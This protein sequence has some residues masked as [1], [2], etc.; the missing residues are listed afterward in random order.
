MNGTQA[1]FARH[2]GV[3][4]SSVKRAVDAGRLVLEADGTLDFE[5]SVARWHATTGGRT[6]VAARHA[7][8]RGA[9]IPK[10]AAGAKNGTAAPK[11]SDTAGLD[12]AVSPVGDTSRTKA[13]ALLVHYENSTIKLGMALRR[14]LRYERSVVKREAGA[15]GAMLRAGIERVI[16]QT[17]P[18]L[19]AA[20]N[21]MERR[22]IIESEVRRLRWAVRRELPRSLRRMKEHSG[23]AK[24][25]S[26]GT[27]E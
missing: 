11:V 24:V 19:A 8:Q 13:K 20:S 12:A 27:A 17:A 21:D 5:K 1:D 26:G 16:D 6:D 23:G 25:G 4:R 10:A 7:A 22:R 3:H 14:G 18:R 2:I 15:I 9:E